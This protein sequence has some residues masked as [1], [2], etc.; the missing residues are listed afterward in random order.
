MTHLRPCPDCRRHVRADETICVFCGVGLP[1]AP[2]LAR[3]APGRFTRAAVFAG[4]AVIGA[5]C[6][7]SE[8][9][10]EPRRESEPFY[11]QTTGGDQGAPDAGTVVVTPT[12][13]AGPQIVEDPQEDWRRRRRNDGPHDIPMPYGA[14]P[15]RDRR[16]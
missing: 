6:G 7:G 16:V 8:K 3:L 2:P 4:A 14:P 12:P 15:A 9:R 5:A 11:T 13:D 1:P 10:D